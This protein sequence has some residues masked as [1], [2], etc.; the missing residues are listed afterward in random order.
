MIRQPIPGTDRRPAEDPVFRTEPTRRAIDQR[1]G[2]LN[3][4]NQRHGNPTMAATPD[5][6]DERGDQ[7][8]SRRGFLK[9]SAGFMAGA[10]SA[11]ELPGIALAQAPGA[12]D[13]ELSRLRGQRRILIKGG[14]VL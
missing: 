3:M 6:G 2:V 8:T 5:T 14:V 1:R 11:Q 7:A 4:S 13:A 9:S 10:A 12:A